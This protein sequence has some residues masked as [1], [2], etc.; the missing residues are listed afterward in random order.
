MKTV[1]SPHF[2]PGFAA[3]PPRQAGDRVLAMT[4]AF[5][6][7]TRF[8]GKRGRRPGA[9]LGLKPVGFA[10]LGL[11]LPMKSSPPPPVDRIERTVNPP[12]SRSLLA[13][14]IA[15]AALA[16]GSRRT[17]SADAG[18]FRPDRHFRVLRRS[19]SAPLRFRDAAVSGPRGAR[20]HHQGD[21]RFEPRRPHRHRPRIAHSLRQ[22]R[23]SR[24]LRRAG[25]SELKPVERLFTGSPDVSESV[26]R[27]AQAAK[28]GGRASEELRLA[29]PPN[30]EGD[31]AWYRIRVRPLE[32][33]AEDGRRCGR[34]PTRRASATGTRPSSRTSSTR[35]TIS[36]MRPPAFS[37]PSRTARSPT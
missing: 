28:S 20:R 27:L 23:L 9:R 12:R 2:R 22:R 32:G 1:A 11:I 30:G 17:P 14:A 6:S 18:D 35:S 3:A 31:V 25:A 21:R 37:P 34:F 16:L 7:G 33:V 4:S 13:S 15:G 10:A 24:A 19:R 26:Y 29:P 36:T 5:D 8:A